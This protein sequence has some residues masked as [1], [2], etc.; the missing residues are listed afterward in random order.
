MRTAPVRICAYA[1]LGS[2][3]N[4]GGHGTVRQGDKQPCSVRWHTDAALFLALHWVLMFQVR[5]P[6]ARPCE[7]N[8]DGTA[9]Y[10]YE[11]DKDA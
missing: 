1:G 11:E 8:A 10:F 4:G 6:A 3:R 9:I 7:L 5:D 2:L